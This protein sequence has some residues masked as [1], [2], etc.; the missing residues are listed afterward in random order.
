MFGTLSN[1]LAMFEVWKSDKSTTPADKVTS[2]GI[3]SAI[4]SSVLNS[5]RDDTPLVATQPAA[6]R[7]SCLDT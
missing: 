7:A 2:W 6:I 1:S 4:E 3:E 5:A